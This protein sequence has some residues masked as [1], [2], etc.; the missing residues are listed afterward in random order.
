MPNVCWETN[1][2]NPNVA[3]YVTVDFKVDWNPDM[4]NIVNYPASSFASSSDVDNVLCDISRTDD[5]NMPS[6]TTYKE[7]DS[8]TSLRTWGG[9]SRGNIGLYNALAL[10]NVDAVILEGETMDLCMSHASPNNYAQHAHSISPCMTGS[11]LTGSTTTKPGACNENGADCFGTNYDFMRTG[12]STSDGTYGG[13]YGLAKDGHV[14]YGPFNADGEVWSCDDVDMCNGFFLADGSYGYAST[15]FFPYLVG[16]WG[17][18]SASHDYLPT[19]TSNGCGTSSS[20]AISG[21]S[22][23]AL[24]VA[25][26]AINSAL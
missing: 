7:Y 23:S 18:A 22:L 19:C 6:T 20:A 15:S 11:A 8:S 9:V 16:C 26:L 13:N 2:R 21:L 10:G 14:I 1:T 25:A 3:N 12:W 4:T 24:A 17:P 5:S